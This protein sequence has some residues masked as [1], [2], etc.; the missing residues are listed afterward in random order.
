MFRQQQ[1]RTRTF[2]FGVEFMRR[3]TKFGVMWDISED[4]V[5]G[6]KEN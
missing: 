6:F 4:V 2:R 1:S 3:L 5:M